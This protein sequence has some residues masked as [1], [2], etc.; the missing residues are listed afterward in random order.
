MK[1]RHWLCRLLGHKHHKMNFG[2]LTRSDYC[3]R[4]G[5]DRAGRCY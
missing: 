5:A 3:F 1:P 2:M 4:C